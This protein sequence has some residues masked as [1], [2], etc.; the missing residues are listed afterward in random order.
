[1]GR[2]AEGKRATIKARS[3]L[4]VSRRQALAVITSGAMDGLLRDALATLPAFPLPQPPPPR[5]NQDLLV[6]QGVVHPDVFVVAE[7]FGTL[8]I[9]QSP[10]LAAHGLP[11]VVLCAGWNGGDA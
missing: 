8:V 6:G 5:T 10:R 7:G 9:K 3:D 2:Q 1:M 11:C 4:S